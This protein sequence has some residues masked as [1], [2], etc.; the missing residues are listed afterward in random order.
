MKEKRKQAKE[1]L[2]QNLIIDEKNRERRARRK[3]RK[4]GLNLGG[5][6]AREKLTS[7][8]GGYKIWGCNSE[9][10]LEDDWIKI[11]DGISL[12]TLET[13]IKKEAL[14]SKEWKIINVMWNAN[15]KY[16][17]M[18]DEQWGTHLGKM[19]SRWQK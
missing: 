9:V 17:Q 19:K 18:I 3:L 7:N 10:T 15:L 13:F 1:S 2:N 6:T 14:G 5:N 4:M 12:D 11:A 8:Y 16:M